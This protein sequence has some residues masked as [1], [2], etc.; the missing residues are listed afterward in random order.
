MEEEIVEFDYILNKQ[1]DKQ[2]KLDKTDL[3][4]QFP[5]NLQFAILVSIILKNSFDC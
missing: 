5:H 4:I 2:D 3:M 1:D